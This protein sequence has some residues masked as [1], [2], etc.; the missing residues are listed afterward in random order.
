MPKNNRAVVTMSIGDKFEAIASLTHPSII[1]YAK[2]IGA[3]FVN[4]SSVDNKNPH[5]NKFQLYDLLAIYKRAIWLDTDLIVRDDCPDLFEMVPEEEIG[6]FEE[7]RFAPRTELMNKAMESYDESL[8]WDGKYF[9]TGVMIISR[10]HR[11]IFRKPFEN[12][13]E[14]S[15]LG[16]INYT[17]FLAEQSYLNV[18][19]AQSNAKI[20]SLRYKFNRMTLMDERTG[21]PRHASYIVHYA[22]APNF[23]EM[24][25]ILKK[26]IDTW[27]EDSPCYDY[28]KNI[29][30]RIGGG[31]GDQV[32]AEPVSRYIIE[33]VYPNEK[34]VIITGFP[35]F[36]S[37]LGVPAITV[38]QWNII[39]KS[40]DIGGPWFVV[41][42][43]PDTDKSPW[44]V[45]THTLSHSVDFSSISS[46]KRMIPD[47][48][49]EIH[50]EVSPKGVKQVDTI[51]ARGAQNMVL[52]HPGHG[53]PS[54]TFP[55][56]WWDSVIRGLVDNGIKV[57]V[58]G[59][60]VSENRK[61]VDV[62]I[63]DGCVDFRDLLSLNGL[64]AAISQAKVLLSNDSSP[65]HI[66]G[67]FD[68]WIV[69]VPT[70]KHPDFVLP[71]RKGSK[72]YKTRSVYN[73]LTVDAVDS[74]PTRISP[75]TLDYVVGDILDYLPPV[76]KVI[77]VVSKCHGGK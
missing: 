27:N 21:E 56:K 19:I 75:Q 34:I 37:H 68:N 25:T 61:Y 10:Y 36:F 53:W 6:I 39:T 16:T 33:N 72:K 63:P 11:E 67:A 7:G 17:S 46:I 28:K 62:E 30:I 23:S 73:K 71:Y 70:C 31:M 55:K 76:E 32:C 4:L 45:F 15:V 74:S 51:V 13:I 66:A 77:N 2:R 60:R 24:L 1:A 52:V 20:F 22:G 48:S 35:E 47:K 50:M 9:N 44:Q 14:E 54:K 18:R 38:E 58:I 49:K 59:K 41:E 65:I 42:T 69:L 43:M 26:D 12:K 5:W 8:E 57:G 3:D 64:I 40:S 29:L